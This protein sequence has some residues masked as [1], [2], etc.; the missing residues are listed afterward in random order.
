MQASVDRLARAE[1]DAR[2]GR[3]EDTS[4]AYAAAAAAALDAGLL[5]DAGFAF[6]EA[7]RC[8]ETVGDDASADELY[9][10]AVAV[11]RA[12][13]S[14]PEHLV[15]V[16]VAWA[17]SAVVTDGYRYIEIA[18]DVLESLERGLRAPTGEE[19]DAAQWQRAVRRRAV[20]DLH[21]TTARVLATI[22]GDDVTA[23]AVD[24]AAR[25]AAAYVR[26]GAV[27]DA[28]HAFWLAGRL[29]DGQGRID[30]ALQNLEAAVEGFARIGDETSRTEAAH[31][32]VELLR[33]NGRIA[34]AEEI[35]ATLNP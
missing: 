19:G 24:R 7:A 13:G 23:K 5:V 34:R 15:Q 14:D 28:A 9:A 11:L 20:A 8:A 1:A 10:R 25:A 27:P 30:E 4:A 29:L 16:I 31:D 6:A 18:D 26:L 22:G 12:G 3:T 2:D 33:W 32:L 35:L 17:P 21:D